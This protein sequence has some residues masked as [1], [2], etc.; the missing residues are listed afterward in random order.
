MATIEILAARLGCTVSYLAD[1]EDPLRAE[2]GGLLLVRGEFALRDR[3]PELATEYFEQALVSGP[4]DARFALRARL[5]LA[6]AAEM[7]QRVDEALNILTRITDDLRAQGSRVPLAVSVALARVQ[8]AAGRLTESIATART[9]LAW[10]VELGLVG[11]NEY[12]QLA[13][14]IVGAIADDGDFSGAA[15]EAAK[16]VDQIATAGD[17]GLRWLAYQRA[18]ELALAKGEGLEAVYLAER[19]EAATRENDGLS[20]PAALRMSLAWLL[21]RQGADTGRTGQLLRHAHQELERIGDTTTLVCC[22]IQLAQSAL[23]SRRPGE[24]TEWARAALD[25][26]GTDTSASFERVHALM[27]LGECQSACEE[28]AAAMSSY[29]E[30]ADL[31][32]KIGDSTEVQHAW[33]EL[34]RML[35]EAGETDAALHAYNRALRGT[36]TSAAKVAAARQSATALPSSQTADDGK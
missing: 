10:A 35:D 1:G 29:Q 24:G 33:A 16:L 19:A 15:A 36:E 21:A 13:T 17:D 27:A 11:F 18:G 31:L 20:T 25:R 23:A 14:V 34:G 12:I 26:V 28:R 8:R 2:D 6:A 32:T 30:A 4:L 9:G 3:S 5:G 22:E 7:L